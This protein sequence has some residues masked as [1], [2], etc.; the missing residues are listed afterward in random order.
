MMIVILYYCCCPL[1]IKI[2][3]ILIY[4]IY[5]YDMYKRYIFYFYI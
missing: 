4:D 5:Q 1:Y 3:N 2:R